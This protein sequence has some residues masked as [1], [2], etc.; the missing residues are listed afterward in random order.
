MDALDRLIVL[1][2]VIALL[3]LGILVAMTTLGN[4][5]LLNWLIRVQTVR[6][7]GFLLVLIL[8]LLALYLVLMLFNEL[9]T[10]KRAIVSQTPLGSVRISIQTISELVYQAVRAI[11]GIKDVKVNIGEVEPLQL[12]LR[13]QLFPDYQVPQ[14]AETVQS[15]VRDYLQQTVG[16]EVAAVN[17]MVT[18]VLSQQ[19][20][21]VS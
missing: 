1:V 6:L 5:V 18:G 16:A 20:P 7:D 13:L 15:S 10:D 21:K 14:L 17:V 19:D 2:V 11:E 8:F 12:D 4:K 3:G 9:K